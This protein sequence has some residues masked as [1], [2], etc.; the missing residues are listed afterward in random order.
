MRAD[1]TDARAQVRGRQA[2]ATDRIE[3]SIAAADAAACARAFVATSFAPALRPRCGADDAVARARSRPLSVLASDQVF[4]T[5]KAAHGPARSPSLA[6]PAAADAPAVARLRA[7]ARPSSSTNMSEFACSCV[8]SSAPR[9]AGP[10]R[11]G[12]ARSTPRIPGS[13][14]AAPSRRVGAAWLRSAPTNLG[15]TAPGGAAKA[16]SLQ[17]HAPAW[18]IE[19][20]SAL[21][22][23]TRFAYDL[24]VRG[25]AVVLHEI[26]A[27]RRVVLAGRPLASLRFGVPTRIVLEGLDPTVSRAFDRALESLSAAGATIETLE[28]PLLG[29]IAAIN[30]SGG[31]AAAES[32]AWHRHLLATHGA[33]TPAGALHSPRR[34]DDAGQTIDL[35]AAPVPG[36]PHGSRSRPTTPALSPTVPIVAHPSSRCVSTTTRSSPPTACC[37]ATRR[38]STCSTAAPSACPARPRARCRPA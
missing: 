8:A 6:R 13:T 11:D 3:Q 14:W 15:S 9:H 17:G 28:L 37:C 34:D 2:R 19:A 21:D 23:S 38:S 24:S 36:S 35:L 32:W 30:A 10:T 29:E 7:P 25:P 18:P 1:L 22:T 26:L 5:F 27:A 31:F 33:T 4:S 20:R 12:A 16:S